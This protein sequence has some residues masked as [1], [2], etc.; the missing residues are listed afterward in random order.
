MHF[1]AVVK[2]THLFRMEKQSGAW[3]FPTVRI[4]VNIAYYF[5]LVV[6]VVAIGFGTFKVATSRFV[7][8]SSDYSLTSVGVP[9]EW[10]T[11]EQKSETK[12]PVL[13]RVSLVQG[14]EKGILHLP[15]WSAAGSVYLVAQA[16]DLVS[17]VLL[18]SVLR[19]IFRNLNAASPFNLANV[20]R[21]SAMGVI[22]IAQDLLGIGVA[23]LLR[24]L[25]KPFV[26]QL[27]DPGLARP[28]QNLDFNTFDLQPNIEG[29]WFLG[30]ILLALAQVYR[31]GIE[32]QAENELTV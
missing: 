19:R 26:T 31:R 13:T 21:I 25:A 23:L 29:D 24:P 20:R 16:L 12:A 9:V 32:L 5:I 10:K 28:L 15:I 1:F 30:L 14:K 4:L 6:A 3:I 17:V 8:E 7:N 27:S 18:L 11:S 2:P 22:L